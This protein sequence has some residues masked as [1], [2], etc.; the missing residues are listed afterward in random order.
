MS[1]NFLHLSSGGVW[2]RATANYFDFGRIGVVA[3][4]CISGFV[5]P[6][7]LRGGRL[8]AIGGF[9]INRFFRLYPIYWITIAIGAYSLWVVSGRQV[10]ASTL[11][12]N[13]A[14]AASFVDE[15]HIMGLF[16]TLEIELVF[17]LATAALFLLFGPY[18]LLASIAGFVLATY[19]WK[20]DLLLEYPGNIPI[21]GYLLAIMF[22]TSAMRCI[23]EIDEEPYFRDSDARRKAAR[24]IFA[25]MA[26]MVLKP[27]FIAIQKSFIDEE[28]IW[29]KYGWGHALGIALFAAFFFIPRVPRWLVAAGR[30]T[31]SAYLLHAI[32]FT[33]LAR[34]WKLQEL[35]KTRLE[36]FILVTSAITFGVAL[37]SYRYLE[38][39]CI[40]LGKSLVAKI[41]R[42]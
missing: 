32:V 9:A 34:V 30:S 22:A 40:R 19:A 2:T 21:L 14:M 8:R 15:P 24:I 33:L 41:P 35:P 23:Y 3:F 29:N 27:L 16:W 4:F 38:R 25:I 18:Q 5:I 20:T 39:P 36:L 7:S 26:Y 37:L 6:S 12:A 1:E 10:P 11:I 31:Y 42:S 28:P 13:I 17:Y